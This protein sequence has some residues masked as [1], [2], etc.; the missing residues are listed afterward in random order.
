M[1]NSH[2]L[3]PHER[4]RRR[5]LLSMGRAAALAALPLAGLRMQATAA[6]ASGSKFLLVFLRGAL[7]T[8]SV[9]VPV[10]SD[11]YY[12]VRPNIAIARPGAQLDAAL[13]LDA[14]WGLHPVLRD[15]L[16]PLYAH[17]ELAFVAF[18]GTDDT[19]R[20]HFETQDSIELGQAPGAARDFG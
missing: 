14:R 8:A 4:A 20:S 3:P 1:R 7:D 9:L 19:S 16:L 12:R 2:H 13:P 15:T 5:A 17:S 6:P 18:A 10:T 11:F